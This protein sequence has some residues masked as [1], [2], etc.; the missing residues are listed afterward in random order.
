M[1]EYLVMNKFLITESD[2]SIKLNQMLCFGLSIYFTH[3][4]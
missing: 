1:K 4:K 2:K 3:E